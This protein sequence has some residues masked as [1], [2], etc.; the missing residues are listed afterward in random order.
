MIHFK[1][2]LLVGLLSILLPLSKGYAEKRSGIGLETLGEPISV[3]KKRVERTKESREEI[4]SS[5]HPHSNI[6]YPPA[7]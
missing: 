5:Y 2:L 4:R 1:N 3:V 7:M 6:V